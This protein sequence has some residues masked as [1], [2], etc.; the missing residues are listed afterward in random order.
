M[1]GR[2]VDESKRATLRRFA[3]AGAALPAGLAGTTAGE[4]GDSDARAA[5]ASY[6]AQTPGAHFSKIRDDLSLGTGE[7]QYHLRELVDGAA[8]TR[9]EDGE[10]TR[11]FPA[12]RFSDDEMTLLTAL[13]RKTPRAMI[14]TL[15]EQPSL[16]GAAL[17]ESIDMSRA[18]V[19]KQASRLAEDGILVRTDGTMAVSEPELALSVL[20]RFAD[21]FD[22]ETMVFAAHAPEYIQ[23]DP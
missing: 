23:Y 11:Y 10:Y 7:T 2:G 20:I 12:G 16:S 21:S 22:R 9:R 14:R 19:S 15:L 4:S 13:R 6:L 5:I 8:I 1:P 18:T 3:A 17:A